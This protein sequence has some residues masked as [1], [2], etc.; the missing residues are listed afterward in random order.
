VN[1]NDN[2]TIFEA[3]YG[4]EVHNAPARSEPGGTNIDAKIEEVIIENLASFKSLKDELNTSTQVV[5]DGLR[6]N[7]KATFKL[8]KNKLLEK[9][10]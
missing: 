4:D 7:D 3:Y 5:M 6:T 8:I 10:S 2:R 9:L 1:T